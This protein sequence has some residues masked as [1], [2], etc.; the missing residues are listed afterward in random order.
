MAIPRRIEITVSGSEYFALDPDQ[1]FYFELEDKV[2]AR[3]DDEEKAGSMK[4]LVACSKLVACKTPR[5]SVFFW[6]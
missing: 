6:V 4:N 3:V 5:F 1:T 2:I